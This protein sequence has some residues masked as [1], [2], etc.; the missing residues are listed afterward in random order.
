MDFNVGIT[1]KGTVLYDWVLAN[2][3]KI[4][5][6]MYGFTTITQLHEFVFLESGSSFVGAIGLSRFEEKSLTD[7]SLSNHLEIFL[8]AEKNDAN[9]K[10]YLLTCSDYIE[11][12]GAGVLKEYR[13]QCIPMLFRETAKR[14]L[15]LGAS[16]GIEIF[17]ILI[18]R[19]FRQMGIEMT[20]LGDASIDSHE[21]HNFCLTKLH[22][23]VHNM[24][25][26]HDNYFKKLSPKVMTIN[27]HQGIC[28]IDRYLDAQV[29]INEESRRIS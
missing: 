5:S 7:Y 6:E 14:G 27:L 20:Y 24:N 17:N 29:N 19:L 26:M 8:T 23:S 25:L 21:V 10:E 15:F 9:I 3:D 1:Q 28:A 16:R 2:I 18:C 11:F 4:Y 12:G 13:E 22:W